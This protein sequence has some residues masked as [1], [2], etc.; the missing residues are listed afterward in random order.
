MLVVKV[1]KTPISERYCRV[2]DEAI[3]SPDKKQINCSGAWFNF[4]ERWSVEVIEQK[5]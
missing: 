4:D 5:K 1:L 2:N 3:L